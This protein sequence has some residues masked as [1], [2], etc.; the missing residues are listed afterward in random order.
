MCYL[1]LLHNQMLILGVYFWFAFKAVTNAS[2][3]AS[4]KHRIST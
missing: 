3:L 4:L 2:I 1:G